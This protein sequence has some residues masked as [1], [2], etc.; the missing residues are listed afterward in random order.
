[1]ADLQGQEL[2]AVGAVDD[3]ELVFV[4]EDREIGG[5]LLK[6]FVPPVLF[7]IFDREADEGG[8]LSSL[9]QHGDDLSGRM[10]EIESLLN[11]AP[12]RLEFPQDC[13]PGEI[14]QEHRPGEGQQAESAAKCC[15]SMLSAIA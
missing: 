7:S 1:M 12:W 14:Q 4:A 6:L 11:R 2:Q 8:F 15:R 10:G 5:A 3:E 9:A 13:P